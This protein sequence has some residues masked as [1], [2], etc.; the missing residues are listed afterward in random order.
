VDTKKKERV[1]NFKTPGREW[2]PKGS[3]EKVNVHDFADPQLGFYTTCG[4]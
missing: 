1:G 2:Q 3:P 4:G